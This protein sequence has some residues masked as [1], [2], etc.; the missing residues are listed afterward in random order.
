MHMMMP[1]DSPGFCSIKAGEL[2]SLSSHYIFKGLC[3]PRMK[4][5]PGHR[6]PQQERRQQLLML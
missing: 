3:K 1:V 5:E 4:Y 2:V 6:I